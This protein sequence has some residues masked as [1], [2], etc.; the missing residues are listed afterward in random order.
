MREDTT[1]SNFL[2]SIAL[3]AVLALLAG[4]AWGQKPQIVGQERPGTVQD[5]EQRVALAEER[6][7]AGDFKKAQD[8]SEA[9]VVEMLHTIE[10][11]PGAGPLVGQ[12]LLVRALGAAG[13]DKMR[14]ALWDWHSARAMNPKLT[15]AELAAYGP[16]GEA[17]L[18]A[19]EKENRSSKSDREAR[20]AR[21]ETAQQTGKR[22]S[23]P[24]KTRGEVPGYPHALRTACTQGV[25]QVESIIDQEGFVTAPAPLSSPSP[26]LTLAALE[27]L[28]TWRFK[29]ASIEGRPVDVYYTLSLTF[30]NTC[31]NPAAIAKKAKEKD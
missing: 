19:V 29:P 20:D 27:A 31:R 5:W 28:R 12:T 16:V 13:R 8:I 22:V 10:S 9:L 11:G 30:K 4:R 26:I 1:S 17:L 7:R 14:E 2:R 6:F 15:S 24:V 23:V 21:T 25:V 18:E 3:C